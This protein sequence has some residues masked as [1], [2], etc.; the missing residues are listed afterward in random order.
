MRQSN[1]LKTLQLQRSS[2]EQWRKIQPFAKL[3]A[4]KRSVARRY[5]AMSFVTK[6]YY[7]VCSVLI[8][9]LGRFCCRNKH[10]DDRISCD[11]KQ[12]RDAW[13]PKP[14]QA[15]K[16]HTWATAWVLVAAVQTDV[17]GHV[18]CCAP[19]DSVQVYLFCADAEFERHHI[20]AFS[21]TVKGHSIWV[22]DVVGDADS[23][24]KIMINYYVPVQFICHRF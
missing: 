1:T 19:F 15:V 5:S 2:I 11:P 13:T 4:Q 17:P 20:R 22:G 18:P 12:K 23:A 3:T 16:F 14:T 21:I 8:T 24:A 7:R 9:A 6:P 10:N